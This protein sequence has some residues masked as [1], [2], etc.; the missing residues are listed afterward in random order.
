MVLS[1]LERGEKTMWETLIAFE[2][3]TLTKRMMINQTKSPGFYC[4]IAQTYQ[5]GLTWLTKQENN[6][7]RN[8]DGFSRLFPQLGLVF[9]SM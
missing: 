9:S 8:R 5:M 7:L 6:Y 4:K 1:L 3:M 2:D